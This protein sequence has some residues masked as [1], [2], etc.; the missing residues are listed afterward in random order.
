[1][2]HSGFPEG[3][4]FLKAS[5]RGE[6]LL[7]YYRKQVGGKATAA[8]LIAD[9]LAAVEVDRSVAYAEAV[10][11]GGYTSNIESPDSVVEEAQASLEHWIWQ[12]KNEAEGDAQ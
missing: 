1:M 5:V 8:D 6:F 11:E 2:K 7:D 3:D 10:A 4:N 9:V 12:I